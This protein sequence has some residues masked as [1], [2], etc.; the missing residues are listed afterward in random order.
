MPKARTPKCGSFSITCEHPGVRPVVQC[1]VQMS[2]VV[3]NGTS[4]ILSKRHIFWGMFEIFSGVY[5]QFSARWYNIPHDFA[6]PS[7]AYSKF[8]RYNC[9]TVG[10]PQFMPNIIKSKCKSEFA[11]IF[12]ATEI[13]W[14][15]VIFVWFSS[16]FINT[17]HTI[18]LTNQMSILH[19]ISEQILRENSQKN[20]ILRNEWKWQCMFW[21]CGWLHQM[22]NDAETVDSSNSC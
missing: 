8:P 14:W 15:S 18:E 7:I 11:H 12:F 22:S 6:V 3:N 13:V 9:V 1:S 10:A 19:R 16:C 5:I 21:V 17:S 20:G 2:C 4:W